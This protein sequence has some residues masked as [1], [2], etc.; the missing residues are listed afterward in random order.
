M[1]LVITILFA[2]YLGIGC[3]YAL[4]LFFFGYDRWY[5][6]PVNLI[7][8]PPTLVVMAYFVIMGKKIRLGD[9]NV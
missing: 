2:V 3:I 9:I 4:W 7:L 8:G 5:W 1:P 6:F